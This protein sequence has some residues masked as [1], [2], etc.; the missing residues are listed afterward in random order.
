MD[1]SMVGMLLTALLC[2]GTSLPPLRA[3]STTSLQVPEPQQ[4]RPRLGVYLESDTGG[5]WVRQVPPGSVAEQAGLKAGDRILELNG[6]PV[7]RAGQVIRA[8]R[9]QPEAKPLEMLLERAG[10]QL[11]LQI[12]LPELPTLRQRVQALTQ[13]RYSSPLWRRDGPAEITEQGLEQAMQPINRWIESRDEGPQWE[14]IA[15]RLNDFLDPSWPAPPWD[16]DQV[17]T[18]ALCLEMAQEG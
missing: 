6:A 14:V 7:Q 12:K 1:K 16:G 3:E 15:G 11:R 2:A 10:R 8:V 13:V 5:V 9:L 18:L 4:R 17:S